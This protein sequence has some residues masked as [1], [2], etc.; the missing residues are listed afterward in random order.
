MTDRS[1]QIGE[2]EIMKVRPSVFRMAFAAITAAVVCLS[3]FCGVARAQTNVTP[4]ND[5]TTRPSAAG[6]AQGPALPYGV[7]E[8]VKMYQGGI[9][10]DVIVNYINTTV[11]PYHLNADGI[12]YLQNLGLP[13][14]MTKAMI[15]RD[16]Q[17]QQQQQMANQQYSPQQPMP[18]AV[19]PPY[20][21][22]MGQTPMGV[23]TPSTPAPP[24]TVVGSDYGD[25][26]YNY[27]YYD[28]G[29]PYYG[30]G[31]PYYGYAGYWPLVIGGWGRGWGYGGYR[32]GVIG[33][34]HGGVGFGG[35]H[36]GVGVGGFHGGGVG[37]AGAGGG[38]AGGGGHR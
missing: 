11:G 38:H 7:G 13:Q 14:E 16:G 5:G 9:N 24:V 25:Y 18:G 12:I 21:A 3:A 20:G 36:G 31:Y 6:A 22:A 33:G 26:G 27:P 28:Y 30:Y 29:Y 8:V 37:H 1:R 10:K 17:L 2:V 35:F 15:L 32:G 34:F 23:M 19:P 4:S